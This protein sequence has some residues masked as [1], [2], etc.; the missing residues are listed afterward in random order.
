MIQI[1][2][3]EFKKIVNKL[4]KRFIIKEGH[5]GDWQI[6]IF[7]EG[8]LIARTK[9]SEGKGDIPP[10]IVQKI[11]KQLYF[12][13]DKELVDFKNCPLSCEGYLNLLRVRDAL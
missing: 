3:R 10:I 9:C 7:H 2:K 8:K 1:K 6:K 11:K 4:K 13:N 12:G 5:T